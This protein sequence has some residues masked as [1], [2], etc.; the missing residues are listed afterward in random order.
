MSWS[1]GGAVGQSGGP[2]ASVASAGPSAASWAAR[3]LQLRGEPLDTL[4]PEVMVGCLT[5][6]RLAMGPQACRLQA[7][8]CVGPCDA[9][10]WPLV[11]QLLRYLASASLCLRVGRAMPL[12]ALWPGCATPSS[13]PCSSAHPTLAITLAEQLAHTRFAQLLRCRMRWAAMRSIARAGGC[14]VACLWAPF[15]ISARPHGGHRARPPGHSASEARPHVS[16]SD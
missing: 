9:L 4:R 8:W 3:A 10:R 13:S 15:P 2:L 1:A 11:P 6:L 16:L 12:S 5:P 14:A 7:R